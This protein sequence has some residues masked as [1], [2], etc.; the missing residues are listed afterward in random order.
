MLRSRRP[1]RLLPISISA[2]PAKDLRASARQSFLISFLLLTFALCMATNLQAQASD[3]ADPEV[4]TPIRIKG[5]GQANIVGLT[6]SQV[7]T[8]YGFAPS[9]S[10]SGQTIAIVVAYDNNTIEEDLAFFSETFGLPSCTSDSGCFRKIYAQ[11]KKPGNHKLW[12]LESALDVEWAHAM[13]PLAKIILVEAKTA[14]LTDMMEAVD[15]AVATN[16]SVISM[17]WGLGDSTTRPDLDFHFLAANKTF[18]AASG[19]FGN[20]VLYPSASPHVI[21]VGGTTLSV[22]VGG[23]YLGETAWSDSGGGLSIAEP[24]PAYQVP[25]NPFD[26]RGTPDVAY[27]GDPDTGFAV[28]N[29]NPYFGLKGWLQIAGTSA[30]VP[31]WAAIIASANS[32]RVAASLPLLTGTNAALYAAATSAYSNYFHDIN[33]GSTNGSCGAVCTTG[34]GYDFVTGLGTP[35]ASALIDALAQ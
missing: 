8:A 35:K 30:G 33:D 5:Q 2:A 15:V 11:G 1:T 25:F 9:N 24:V 27:N 7:K 13:A 26:K 18:V 22:G 14:K 34:L 31:Q 21:S 28:Y 17:S 16:A 32:A 19:D 29:S 3:P 10:G 12:S 6:P 4:Q 20:F 23:T